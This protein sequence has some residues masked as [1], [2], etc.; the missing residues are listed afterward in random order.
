M[1]CRLMNLH[2]K[3][4]RVDLR[5][6]QVLVLDPG[7]RSAVLREE[8]LYDNHHVPEWER[9]GWVRRFAARLSDVTAA[10]SMAPVQVPVVAAAATA[11]APTS[12]QAV[13]PKVIPALRSSGVSAAA[14][15]APTKP[16]RAAPK[17]P[18]PR[19]PK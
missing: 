5:G 1:A 9:L 10:T 19:R 2:S 3:P 13:T 11:S 6:G 17:K 16:Q 14:K 8:L 12:A 18:D 4:M 7:E 15:K